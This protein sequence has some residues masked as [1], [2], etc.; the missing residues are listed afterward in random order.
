MLAGLVFLTP[1]VT[2]NLTGL[3]FALPW[4][5]DAVELPRLTLS[6]LGAVLA[7]LLWALGQARDPLP[8]RWNW[9]LVALSLLAALSVASLAFASNWRLGV[10]GQ[11]ERLEGVVAFVVYAVLFG[12][13]LQAVRG[14]RDVRL[15]ASALVAAAALSAGY[16]ILQWLGIDPTDYL[17]ANPGFDLRRAFAAF[18]N[19]NF[20][21]GLLVLAVPPAVALASRQRRAGT[22]AGLWAVTALIV[23]GLLLTFTRGAL[24]ALLVESLV[25]LWLLAS[26][27]VRLQRSARIGAAIVAALVLVVGVASIG[28]GGEIDLLARLSVGARSGV[29]DRLL[30]WQAA[31]EASLA[32]PLFGYGPD[33]FLTAFRLHRPDAYA[34][35][36]GLA[37]TTS[38]A[39]SWPLQ[40]AA[41]IGAPAAIVFV[42]AVGLGLW[43]G[44]RSLRSASQD[45][46]VPDARA[47]S[48]GDLVFAGVWVGCL[49][50]LV[51]TLTNVAVHGVTTPFWVMLA[52]V[53]VP[54]CWEW[55]PRRVGTG[56][57]RGVAVALG[58]F[59]ALAGVVAVGLLSADAA[60]LQSRAAYR[61]QLDADPIERAE[62]AVALNP[63]SVKYDRGLAEV[64]ADEY[65]AAAVTGGASS[66]DG[67]AAGAT[68][69]RADARF[70]EMLTR[71][72]NDYAG[73]AWHAAL[74]A[75]AVS[76]GDGE[77]AGRAQEAASRAAAL[78]RHA[79]Q[80]TPILEGETDRGAVLEALG[81]AGLP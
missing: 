40:V 34:D 51:H 64:I 20:L 23:V 31:V 67:A 42:S 66:A 25:A 74:L 80:V 50:Y 70:A 4:L 60:Y 57:W 56:T 48:A 24:L 16:G 32:R 71:Y 63:L 19:P 52:V 7:L 65:Y 79:A 36:G 55:S 1:L 68:F 54:A 10:L 22:A 11:S 69:D 14:V 39:H 27:R 21:A 9:S 76:Q 58:V 59:L 49:G 33:L 18:G 3:G 81:V 53:T 38:N 30:G 73:H 29:L 45:A 6:A 17:V 44:V 35:I 47:S 78:D 72:P 8:V 2:A 77:S 12:V 5:Y 41:T 75:S 46:G 37:G 62:R 28:R 61:G 13:T 26:G 15:L 43:S